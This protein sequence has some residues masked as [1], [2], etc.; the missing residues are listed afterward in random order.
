MVCVTIAPDR[1]LVAPLG[2]GVDLVAGQT[3]E[4]PDHVAADWIARGWAIATE[5]RT[6][7]SAERKA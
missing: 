1:Y 6:A 2:P 4:V 3:I 5:E 7:P